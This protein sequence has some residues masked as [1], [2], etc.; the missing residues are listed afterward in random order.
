MSVEQDL[1]N[2]CVSEL[3]EWIKKKAN[4]TKGCV[5]YTWF[6]A[7]DEKY[8]PYFWQEYAKG[9]IYSVQKMISWIGTES[10]TT[11]DKYLVNSSTDYSSK[12]NTEYN[13][14]SSTGYGTSN[15]TTTD[16]SNTNYQYKDVCNTHLRSVT[17]TKYVRVYYIMLNK[18]G[19]ENYTRVKKLYDEREKIRS[20][21]IKFE[22]KEH[23]DKFDFCKDLLL[24][25]FPMNFRYMFI[26]APLVLSYISLAFS[27]I[28]TSLYINHIKF[29]WL[30]FLISFGL[31]IAGIWVTIHIFCYY[32]DVK[33]PGWGIT[34]Y[35]TLALS[36]FVVLFHGGYMSFVLILPSIIYCTVKGLIR[37]IKRIIKGGKWEKAKVD[38]HNERERKRVENEEKE[39]K[40]DLERY[41]NAHPSIKNDLNNAREFF[42]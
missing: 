8:L 9:K 14:Y 27:F 42:I 20:R 40:S 12:S 1:T 24:N 32:D 39:R 35:I 5:W 22:E 29:T 11:H 41:D 19:Y 7:S 17:K 30:F 34:Y 13:Y 15:R 23:F 31:I 4:N 37:L 16:R 33:K 28:S 6:V 10:Y 18:F 36:L 2:Q 25:L 21:Y 26:N 38:A 3:V